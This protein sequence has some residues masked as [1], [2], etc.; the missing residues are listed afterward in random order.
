MAGSSDAADGETRDTAIVVDVN[1]VLD[2]QKLTSA[3]NA[4]LLLLT[5]LATTTYGL[6]FSP[7]ILVGPNLLWEWGGSGAA[8][9]VQLVVSIAA[10]LFVPLIL[11]YL[12]DRIGRKRV[13]IAIALAFGLLSLA[14]AVAMT[15]VTTSWRQV[16]VPV[17]LIAVALGGSLPIL[18]SLVSELAPQRSRATMVILV[19]AGISFGGGLRLMFVLDFMQPYG[20]RILFGVAA[21]APLAVALALLLALPESAKYLTLHSGRRDELIMLLKRIDPTIEVAPETRFAI[22]GE[23][24]KLRFSPATLFA[25]PL[26]ALTPLYWISNFSVLMVFNFVLDKMVLVLMASGLS[27]DRTLIAVM[28]FQFSGAL[29]GLSTM[30]FLDKFGFWPVPILFA[31][32]IPVVIGIDIDGFAPAALLAGAWFCLLG[33]QFGNIA[34]GANLYPTYIR[35][36]ALGLNFAVARLG[37]G[38]WPLLDDTELR[39]YFNAWRMFALAAVL[40]VVGLIAA[41]LIVPRYRAALKRRLAG[42][43]TAV[44]VQQNP[45]PK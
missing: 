1:A 41:L 9:S 26:A 42:A 40:L 33:V 4:R 28:F 20:P 34:T 11:G 23:N 27:S 32:A 21:F 38:L 22:T 44:A 10:G 3:F 6:E 45:E 14:A 43:A 2:R 25:G 29:G 12:A 16:N 15:L 18:V 30:L 36:F 7:T 24:N 19:L 35:A 8:Y 37:S 17:T 5:F 13:I 31:C 39:L